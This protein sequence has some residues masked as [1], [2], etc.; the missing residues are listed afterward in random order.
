M[1]RRLIQVESYSGGRADERP[2][3]VMID[4]REHF[5]DRLLSSSL[6]ESAASKARIRKFKVMTRCGLVLDIV[7]AEDEWYL[8]SERRA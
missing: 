6:E 2:R 7:Q 3:R 1:T 5:I 8:E 4:G